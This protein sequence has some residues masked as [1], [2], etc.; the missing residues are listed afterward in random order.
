MCWIIR[1]ERLNKFNKVSHLISKNEKKT[2]TT[3]YE[4]V[5]AALNRMNV[6]TSSFSWA[7][8][9]LFQD[10]IELTESLKGKRQLSTTVSKED[11][12]SILQFCMPV[13]VHGC[14]CVRLCWCVCL[15]VKR[16]SAILI[17]YVF[18][19]G[20]ITRFGFLYKRKWTCYII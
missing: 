4:F 8:I 3:L 2:K 18:I 11:Y 12:A 7:F 13:S 1:Y 20:Y 17:V 6:P 9:S 19:L 16:P 10:G 5:D 14:V 15:I